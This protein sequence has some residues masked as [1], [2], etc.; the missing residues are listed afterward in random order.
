MRNGICTSL[1][2]LICCLIF[3]FS[4]NAYCQTSDEAN[5]VDLAAVYRWD[6]LMCATYSALTQL[7]DLLQDPSTKK[8]LI[9]SYGDAVLLLKRL[10]DTN[11]PINEG[12]AFLIIDVK[13]YRAGYQYA[14]ELTGTIDD[15]DWAPNDVAHVAKLVH[16][17]VSKGE[18][19]RAEI[20]QVS[21]GKIKLAEAFS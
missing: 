19:L 17:F 10:L 11:K 2:R 16:Q 3:E 20:K 18:F 13:N 21:D 1:L 15:L 14:R 4:L 7:K 5:S 8:Q 6:S 12:Y 9:A